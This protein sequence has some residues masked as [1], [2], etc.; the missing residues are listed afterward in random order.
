MIDPVALLHWT[1]LS[2]LT[3][4][5]LLLSVALLIV[6]LLSACST[7]QA[8]EPR[9]IPFDNAFRSVGIVVLEEPDSAPL[10]GVKSFFPAPDGRLFV[11][12]EG[13]PQ[14]RIFDASGSLL[15]IV[16]RHGDGPGEFLDPS[17]AI[18]DRDGKL[19]VADAEDGSVTRFT[20]DLTYDTAFSVPGFPTYALD[21]AGTSLLSVHWNEPVG[22][23]D[24]YLT[25]LTAEGHVRNTLHK[26]DSLVWAIPY[27]S[28]FAGPIGAASPSRIVSG[29]M[30][31]YPL[32][33]YEGNGRPL[34]DFG[35]PP[36]S[37]SP[38]GRPE[39][40]A[41]I[42]VQGRKRLVEWLTAAMVI[43]G[44]GIYR[45]SA[46]FVVHA[47]P[48]PQVTN[49]YARKDT[50]MDIY[51]LEGR[52]IVTDVSLP[53]RFLRAGEYLYL[54]ESTPPDDWR[55]GIYQLTIPRR[56]DKMADAD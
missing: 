27:W 51:D 16:G 32:H 38:P 17:D 20:E 49:F 7:S 55:V 45:D 46:I 43:S 23:N 24:H 9:K 33:L 15:R 42:G 31:M 36:T 53:G 47:K 3:R 18:V 14:V 54:L 28:S 56:E 30:F 34:K 2:N 4:M 1:F 52:K 6:C 11:V 29:N 35:D 48:S 10:T 8:P 26:V 12:D 40:G 39:R 37:W 13:R 44:L 5:K 41:F 25:L 19:F 50:L 22:P 21:F